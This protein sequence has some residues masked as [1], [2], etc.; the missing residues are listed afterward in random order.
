MTNAATTL[1]SRVSQ[2]LTLIE[3]GA[4]E[5][6][7]I[8]GV[9]LARGADVLGIRMACPHPALGLV[10]DKDVLLTM[11]GPD[12]FA[13]DQRYTRVRWHVPITP[14]GVRR[15]GG[16]PRR[17]INAPLHYDFAPGEAAAL[18]LEWYRED[19]TVHGRYTADAPVRAGL[20][21]N[22]CF[23][24]AT[25]TAAAPVRC[26]LELGDSA[27]ELALAGAVET[28][29]PVDSRLQA[30]QAWAGAIRPEGTAMAL[31]PVTLGPG[32]PLHFVMRLEPR[33][34]AAGDTPLPDPAAIDQHLANGAWEYAASRMC[35]TGAFPG[36]AEAIGG[37]A[38]YSRT[39]DPRRQMLQT[40]VN[41]TWGEPNQP[42][43]IFGWDNFFDSYIAA[44]ENPRLG[45]A[46]L[47]HIVSIYGEKGIAHGPTQRNL[48]IPIIYCRTLD[49][50]ADADLAR[51]TWPVMMEFMR[52]WFADRGDGRP[53]RDGN[54]D[55]L[56]EAGASG[57]PGAVTP[58][59]LIQ[60]AMDETGYDE[61]PIYSAGFT[62]GRLGMLADGVE[63]DGP[64]RTL[65][66]TLL[67]QNCL[68]IASAR[69]MARRAERLGHT[70]DAAWL[71]GEADRVANRVR[72][73]LYCE[74][75]G[76]YRDRFWNGDF[77]PVKAMTIFYPLLA[78]LAD[79][80]V[81]VRL[82]EALLDPKQFWGDNLIP[83]VSRD[84]PAYCDGLDGQG[85]Y[86]RGNCWPPTTYM[87]YLAIK[88]AGWDD[89]AAEY[90]RRVCGQ[91]MEYW[92]AHGHAYE[93]YP[94][95]GKVDARFLYVYGWGGRELRY[96]W[97]GMLPLCG[98]EEIFAPEVTCAGVRFG[99]PHLPEQS[100][101][102]NFTWQGQ[103][104]EAE[105]GPQRTRVSAGG[106]WSFLAEPGIVVRGFT[107]EDGIAFSAAPR[108]PSR[109]RLEAKGLEP[110]AEISVLVKGRPIPFT[111]EGGAV[112]F[113]LPAGS[114]DVRVAR[115]TSP[116]HQQRTQARGD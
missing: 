85:N 2:P 84:D 61:I 42:G 64:S 77:S 41:R 98:L 21:V 4:F 24:P 44:W 27:L 89:I 68:Y 59:I 115:E 30:E 86:W 20:F 92:R 43:L 6:Q 17:S 65:T 81:K 104:V 33:T 39:Y 72:E 102:R 58:G 100:V 37:L 114:A 78:G 83:T 95:E 116:R 79:D 108:E 5:L 74:K 94:A 88:E 32:R 82:K 12:A 11:D 55:G 25:V 51:R 7:G 106:A 13:P 71:R 101:W 45:A 53:W 22:G 16:W 96:V 35:S 19:D 23:A 15:L 69:I 87:V 111:F 3:S 18:T 63:F 112:E 31:Y 66:I 93:N 9:S 113:V 46:S 47:E 8:S 52:F 60:E 57:D 26:R 62:E 80:A 70:D 76:F 90:A 50:L 28:P 110:P 34:A 107:M 103:T 10:D 105:A 38:G 99:N 56:I 54:G 49:I 36:A 75:D 29:L 40:T 1:S 73:R 91:F 48:I 109:L 14:A 67:C 97:S